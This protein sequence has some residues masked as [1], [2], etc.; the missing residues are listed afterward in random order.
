MTDAER[1][2]A[3]L[4]NH[5]ICLCLGEELLTD[6]A[7]GIAPMMRFLSEGRDLA[8]WSVA[9]RIVGKAAAMLFVKAGVAAVYGEVMSRAGRD[10]LLSHGV[11][12]EAGTL[13][14]RIINRAG[15]GICPMEATVAS[16][17]DVEEGYAAL[18]RKLEAL[19]AGAR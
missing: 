16:L 4:G 5:S 13:T 18:V 1:A 12:A 3:G 2:K 11:A 19:R 6:D 9:D 8:G 14:D 7:R 15:T 10:Y 17:S